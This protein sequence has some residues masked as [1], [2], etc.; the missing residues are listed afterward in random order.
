MDHI[1]DRSAD[2]SFFFKK[3]KKYKFHKFWIPGCVNM[4]MYLRELF[5]LVDSCLK[6]TFL[7]VK[8]ILLSIL[9]VRCNNCHVIIYKR[10]ATIAFNKNSKNLITIDSQYLL[11]NIFFQWSLSGVVFDGKNLKPKEIKFVHFPSVA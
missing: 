11:Q 8:W 5:C 1:A 10:K 3:K 9:R 6:M 7:W 2:K 4:Y